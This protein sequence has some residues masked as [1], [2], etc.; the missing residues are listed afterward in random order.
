MKKHPADERAAHLNEQIQN[1]RHVGAFVL[2]RECSHQKMNIYAEQ[3][4]DCEYVL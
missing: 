3:R 2:Q 1:E 4:T